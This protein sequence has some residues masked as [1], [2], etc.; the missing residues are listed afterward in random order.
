ME[1]NEERRQRR[2]TPVPCPLLH[3][4]SHRTRRASPPPWRRRW[5]R[6]LLTTIEEE[7]DQGEVERKDRGRRAESGERREVRIGLAC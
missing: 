3:L 1:I 4:A 6:P 7:Q 5:R 2:R